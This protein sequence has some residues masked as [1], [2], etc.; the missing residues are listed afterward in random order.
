[1]LCTSQIEASTSP[2]PGQLPGHF[3]FWKM[4]VQISPPRAE[5]LFNYPHS[6][7]NYQITVLTFQT[8]LHAMSHLFKENEIVLKHLQIR[9]KARVGL[10][11][12]TTLPQIHNLFL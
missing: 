8:P 12:S 7:E 5:K 1:M 9:N 11:F 10:C 6:R 2:P 4:F 3:N